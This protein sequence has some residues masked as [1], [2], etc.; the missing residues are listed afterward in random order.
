[1][2]FVEGSLINS[3]LVVRKAGEPSPQVSDASQ[4][5][6]IEL[7]L[8]QRDRVRQR[9]IEATAAAGS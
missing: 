8:K 1:V 4:D 2:A 3:V 7:A 9:G 5:E 6:V